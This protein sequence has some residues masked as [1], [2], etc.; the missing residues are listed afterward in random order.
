[1]D[2]QPGACNIRLVE[3][4]R[5]L[6][7]TMY[8]SEAEAEA[9][10]GIWQAIR[11]DKKGTTI[12]GTSIATSKNTIEVIRGG[13]PGIFAFRRDQQYVMA[14]NGTSAL[15]FSNQ[16]QHELPKRESDFKLY[17]VKRQ[18]PT[19]ETLLEN[20]GTFRAIIFSVNT[21][22]Y[23]IASS[24]GELFACETDES[25]AT[26]FVFESKFAFSH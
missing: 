16:L 1:M 12:F 18:T 2:V 5:Y 11:V 20:D 21:E 14:N 19:S 26:E 7:P 4:K 8:N 6:L 24:S 9:A 13:T 22:K 3:P 17:R 15:R 10:T 23:L 25:G